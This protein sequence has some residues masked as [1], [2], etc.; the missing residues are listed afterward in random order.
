MRECQIAGV[1]YKNVDLTAEVLAA[2]DLVVI[3]TDHE[4]VDY[5]LVA[6][7]AP[8]IFDTRNAMKGVDGAGEKLTKL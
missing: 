1:T 8:R 5:D 4:S 7:H 2:S 6:Q 3:L